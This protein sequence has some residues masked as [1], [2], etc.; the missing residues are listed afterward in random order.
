MRVRDAF[1]LVAAR[2]API[3]GLTTLLVVRL[4]MIVPVCAQ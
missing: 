1:V 4:L 3:L 2:S